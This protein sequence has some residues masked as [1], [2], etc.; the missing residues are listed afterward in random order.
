MFIYASIIYVMYLFMLQIIVSVFVHIYRY[1]YIYVAICDIAVDATSA[2][3]YGWLAAH[4]DSALII[5]IPYIQA[6]FDAYGYRCI[7]I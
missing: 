1:I 5:S 4:Y 7:H 2:Y 3:F 6:I